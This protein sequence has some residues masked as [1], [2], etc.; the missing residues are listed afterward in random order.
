MAAAFGSLYGSGMLFA[1]YCLSMPLAVIAIADMVEVWVDT[2][3][4]QV[5]C[6]K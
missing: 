2:L 4:S 5:R 3:P 6:R 1:L